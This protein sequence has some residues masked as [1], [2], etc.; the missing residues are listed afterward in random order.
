MTPNRNAKRRARAAAEEYHEKG[1]DRA[2]EAVRDALLSDEMFCWL[3]QAASQAGDYGHERW[4]ELDERE[5]P[6][7]DL[8]TFLS[9]A[10]LQ[11][12]DAASER[13]DQLV[14][15]ALAEIE[16]DDDE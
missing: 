4:N 8:R 1:R 3:V 6:E 9:A 2:G 14:A 5:I 16:E 7:D 15:E 11:L 10:E 12:A 13:E